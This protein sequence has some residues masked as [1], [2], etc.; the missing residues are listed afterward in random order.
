MK[1]ETVCSDGTLITQRLHFAPAPHPHRHV[2]GWFR[3][4]HELREAGV[5][6]IC[7][8]DGKE[9]HAAKAQEVDPFSRTQGLV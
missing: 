5:S 1:T 9:R 2:I 7:V 3:L 6:A 8:F 4:V